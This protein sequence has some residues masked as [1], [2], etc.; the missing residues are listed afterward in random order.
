MTNRWRIPCNVFDMRRRSFQVPGAWVEYFRPFDVLPSEASFLERRHETLAPWNRLCHPW[1]LKNPSRLHMFGH[2]ILLSEGL[3]LNT[4]D[5]KRVFDQAE[6][7]PWPNDLSTP[8]SVIH[9]NRDSSNNEKAQSYLNAFRVQRFF[10]LFVHSATNLSE[11]QL[12]HA[13]A[14]LLSQTKSEL[15]KNGS[16]NIIAQAGHFRSV[17]ILPERRHLKVQ[18]LY[19][20]AK[21]LPALIRSWFQFMRFAD[22]HPLLR[23]IRG[24]NLF[25]HIHP[26]HDGNGR[27]AKIMLNAWLMNHEI[28][29]PDWTRWNPHEYLEALR[30]G[31][32]HLCDS[33]F[34]RMLSLI[35]PNIQQQEP[36]SSIERK[37]NVNPLVHRLGC[38]HHS[39]ETRTSSRFS[40]N[41][42]H[43]DRFDQKIQPTQQTAS[44]SGARNRRF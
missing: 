15:I 16:G 39:Q 23:L 8:I 22:L 7:I 11:T 34:H 24:F 42:A 27:L 12:L 2:Q 14:C 1:E 31:N 20:P 36:L 30:D 29:P 25:L 37:K 33:L 28:M 4:D 32:V 3:N 19:A 21:E 18:D 35:D 17:D 44:K 5:S 40:S 38:S 13:H 6:C 9:W 41:L 43:R 26:F 10:N